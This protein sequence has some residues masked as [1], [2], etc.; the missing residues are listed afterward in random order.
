MTEE[1][2]KLTIDYLEDMKEE[3]VEG[4]GNERYPLPEWYMLDKVIKI[5]EQQPSERTETH[6][7]DCI[8]RKAVLDS[9][10]HKFAD[11][12]DSDKWW[13]SISVLYAINETP[14]FK[15]QTKTAIALE[16]YKDLQDYFGDMDIART[17]LENPKEFK[18]W[19]ERLRWNTKKVDELARKLE[20]L[21]SESK[22]EWIPVKWHNITDEERKREDYP[23][24]WLTMPDCPMP[25]DDEEILVTVKSIKCGLHVEKDVCYIDDGFSLDSGND[26][27]DDVVAW[28]PLPSSYQGEENG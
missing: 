24:E 7:C 26:W 18:A 9:L 2:R 13:N 23:K 12:F 1:E 27:I 8:S 3:C 11:G 22:T 21:E 25:N 17:V 10:H 19:L 15:P 6:E 4:E 14:S 20:A 28:M 5:I 16:R